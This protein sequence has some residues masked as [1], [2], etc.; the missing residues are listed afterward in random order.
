MKS[1]VIILN[2]DSDISAILGEVE[3]VAAYRKLEKKSALR[4]R[5]LAEELISMLPHLLRIGNGKF[6]IESEGKSYDMHLE[7]SAANSLLFDK[8]RVLEISKSGEN[9]AYKGIMGKIRY[10]VD[11][12]L[13]SSAASYA[14]PVGV[15]APFFYSVGLISDSNDV[16]GNNAWSLQNYQNSVSSDK[17]SLTE[18]WD[19]LEKSIIGNLADDV[20]VGI[21]GGKIHITVK[22]QF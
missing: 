3:S 2:A 16:Y 11:F 19:E 5:L 7:V 10:A 21:V 12:M 17:E 22:K 18:E 1:D 20:I 9:A 8:E 15:D 4:L 14:D 6:W 13:N